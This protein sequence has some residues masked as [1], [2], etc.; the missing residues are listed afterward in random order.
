MRFIAPLALLFAFACATPA[1]R[2]FADVDYGLGEERDVVVQGMRLR[3]YEG[4]KRGAPAVLLLHCFG[5]SMKVWRDFV[6]FLEERYHVVAYDAVGHGKSARGVRR[7]D[8][9]RLADMGLG[10]M[11]ALGIEEAAL[12]GNSMGGGTALFMALK[13][14]ERVTALVL[15]D[16]VGLHDGAFYRPFFSFVGPRDIDTAA[17]WT[18]G[19]VYDL[20]VEKRSPLVEEIREDILATRRDGPRHA[21]FVGWHSLLDAIF[22]IDRTGDLS[23]VTAPTLVLVGRHDRLVNVDHAERLARGI[24]GARFHVFEDL[25]HLPEIEDAKQVASVVRPFLD[26]VLEAR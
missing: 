9:E 4:G 6:P 10:V 23:R 24:P 21:T 11:D 20:A 14:P 7:I 19:L 16:A 25:G 15:V 26:E 18:W 8:L 17:D 12:V 5:L 13:A 2:S 3:V 1:P 22:S